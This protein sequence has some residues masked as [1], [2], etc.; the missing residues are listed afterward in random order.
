MTD[1][2]P[3]GP[4]QLS[5]QQ[6]EQLLG[7]LTVR[8]NEDGA[9]ATASSK[10]VKPSRPTIDIDTSE[11]EWS[12]F[13]DQWARFKRMANLTDIDGIRDNLRQCCSVQLNKRLFDV[14]GAATLN[15]AAEADLLVWIKEIAVKGMH[16]EVHR[17]QFVHCKQK[18]GECLNSYHGRLK[19]ESKLCDFRIPAPATCSENTCTCPN[20]GMQIS[21]QDDMVATQLVAG[22]YNSEHQAKVLSESATLVTLED[23]L[24]RLA[25]LETSDTSLSSLAGHDATIN[26]TRGG[27]QDGR[28]PDNRQRQRGNRRRKKKEQ[29]NTTVPRPSDGDGTGICVECGESHPQCPTC[30]GYHKCSTQCNFCKKFGHIRNCCRGLLK[31]Q[32]SAI[33]AKLNATTPLAEGDGEGEIAFGLSLQVVPHEKQAKHAEQSLSPLPLSS[34]TLSVSL[35]QIS[36]HMLS[37]MEHDGESFQVQKPSPAPMIHVKCKIIVENHAM[38]GRS[39]KRKPKSAEEDGLADTGAQVCT[40]GP[41]LLS[42][43][44]VDVDVLIPTKLEVKGITHSPVTMLGALFLEVSSNGMCTKQIVYIAREARSLI[45]SETALKD[46][47]VLPPDFP[48]AGS[49]KENQCATVEKVS[50]VE[51]CA[52]LAPKSGTAIIWSPLSHRP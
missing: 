24:K 26:L 28:G 3:D 47:G 37:H 45:L 23:K 6:F 41:D 32:L 2:T 12:V 50:K 25:V 4:I 51:K 42:D 18:Q 21:Y 38:Y 29:P 9:A 35:Q 31:Q 43:L 27:L 7:R 46:L 39:P 49:F 10:S 30:K 48:T 14:K 15:A 22:L 17:T 34:V 40:G 16:K 44:H 19:A 11:G 33:A 13:E 5:Q 20:H 36:I 52:T 1:A 8:N